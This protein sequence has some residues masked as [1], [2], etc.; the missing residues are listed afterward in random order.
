[1]NDGVMEW[2]DELFIYIPVDPYK[3]TKMN[4]MNYM[5]NI[6]FVICLKRF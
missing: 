2:I 5:R 3:Y 4:Y 6:I 1:M